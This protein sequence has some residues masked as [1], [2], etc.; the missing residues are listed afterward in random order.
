MVNVL[1]FIGV[2]Y[3]VGVLAGAAIVWHQTDES[4]IIVLILR[5]GTWPYF[6]ARPVALKIGRDLHGVR[7]PSPEYI[8]QEPRS[9]RELGL[10]DR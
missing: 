2:M 10:Y 9:P 5:G 7:R 1:S 8:D 3:V 6:I 4:N